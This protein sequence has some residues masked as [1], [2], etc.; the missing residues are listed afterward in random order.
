MKV[1]LRKFIV[2][3][4]L[5]VNFFHWLL[6]V[7]SLK[8]LKLMHHTEIVTF[9]KMLASEKCTVKLYI[10]TINCVQQLI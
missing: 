4:N 10:H 1:K 9:K 7:K 2:I 3:V 5:G 6:P 8:Y